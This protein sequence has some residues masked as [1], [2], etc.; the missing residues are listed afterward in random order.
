MSK[1]SAIAIVLVALTFTLFFSDILFGSRVLITAN[2]ARWLPWR[3][4]APA[5]EAR[6]PG[7]RDDSA[8]TYFPR[9]WLSQESMR[10]GEAPLW[11][12]HVLGGTPHLADFQS[13]VYHPLN[14]I[15]YRFDAL[16]ATGI[17]LYVHLLAGAL[18]LFLF[19]RALG[20]GPWGG[21]LGAIAFGF[22][23]YFATYIGHPVHI[24]TGCWLPFLLLAVRR[25]VHGRGWLAL[26]LVVA[27]LF[28]GGFP[29]T[30]LYSLIIAG[31]YALFEAGAKKR[32]IGIASAG[33][34]VALGI[35]LVLFQLLPT[36]ELG[37]LSDRTAI[38]LD[39]IVN[40]HQPEPIT[41]IRA[42]V[43]DFFGNP[44]DETYW[45]HA[46]DG[47]I[48]HPNDIG[49]LGYAGLATLALALL[50]LVHS[51]R[52]EKWFFLAVAATSLL[53]LF[54]SHA[55]SLYY[56][57]V[58]F[59]RFS[60]ELHRLQFPFLFA[61]CVL[62]G[63]GW[64][65]LFET[66]R[67]DRQ[68]E[69]MRGKD[70]GAA[71]GPSRAGRWMIGASLLLVIAFALGG[72]AIHRAASR[73]YLETQ[74][75]NLT[76]GSGMRFEFGGTMQ[77]PP[78]AAA[79]F[80]TLLNPEVPPDAWKAHTWKSVARAALMLALLGVAFEVAARS[81]RPDTAI[82]ASPLFLLA[83][84]AIL[85]IHVFDT[86]TFARTYYTNSPRET[87]FAPHPSIEKLSRAPGR[88]A[89]LGGQYL[90]PPNTA[91]VYGIDDIAGVN[92]LMP[93]SYGAIFGA[94]SPALFPDGRR[95]A[96]FSSIGELDRP[97]WDLLGMRSLLVGP[98]FE[99]ERVVA[100][101]NHSGE[102]F[103]IADR[104]PSY[105]PMSSWAV[106]ENRNALPFAFLIHDYEVVTDAGS[107]RARLV[108][109]TFDARG[110]I[111]LEEDPGF[112]GTS[113]AWD[114]GDAC[115]FTRSGGTIRVTTSSSRDGLLFV[116]ENDV[117]GWSAEVDGV[118]APILRA[119][120][121]FRA[122]PV[123]RGDHEIVL[124][125]APESWRKG[126]RFSSVAGAVYLLLTALHLF[127]KK[128]D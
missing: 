61:L 36:K 4:E 43:P 118:A 3:T 16:R 63:L 106:L 59:A 80:P 101:L 83:A 62:A 22:N 28:L 64:N 19:L 20:V 35:G 112:T 119:H 85:L 96:P 65:A 44:V 6:A 10:A 126:I 78:V 69:D 60:S 26:P 25:A 75:A 14:L 122:I 99:P 21:A 104:Y 66:R 38:P 47:P 11:N 5:L 123:P 114:P 121:T 100:A 71:P 117:P 108:S 93:A 86:A 51:R 77:M 33:A 84:G 41:A 76:T 116:C 24:T 1:Q 82:A 79:W 127:R 8:I 56:K 54:S 90:L 46:F 17:F 32:W 67:E 109:A 34:G 89:R 74:R 7:F 27:M 68:G 53:L 49:F 107:A 13:G 72:D 45:I 18:G 2:M 73:S 40:V 105:M 37:S 31:A 88:I 70:A 94:V 9:R 128:R 110:P 124:R 55:Y 102:R 92:A 29:Q 12:P 87:A 52:R 115:D 98:S 15:L 91:L 103:A 111:L 97:V 81:R 30:I 42:L 57:L 23:A 120:T 58:P 95:I 125:Y 113:P 48:P 50:A 39:K